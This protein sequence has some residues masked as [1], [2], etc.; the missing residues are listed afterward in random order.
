MLLIEAEMVLQG[1]MT[2]LGP[3]R[4]EGRLQGS[5][6]CTSIEVGPYAMV[7]GTLVAEETLSISGQLIGVGWA[8]RIQLAGTAIVEGELHQE[9]LTMD[10]HAT[11]V[12]ESRREPG[13]AMPAPYVALQERQ[14]QA[15]SELDSLT[16]E[17]RARREAEADEARTAFQRLRA[18]FPTPRATG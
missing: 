16:A 9:Q 4:I 1:H 18:R 17:S 12:G 13:F 5:I 11:L 6:V 7:E 15:Q 14:R 10:E 8:K 2:F 3:C